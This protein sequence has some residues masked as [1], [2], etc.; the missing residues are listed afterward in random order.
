M[1]RDS[2][3]GS[4]CTRGDADRLAQVLDNLLDNAIRYTQAG[5]TVTV[6]LRSIENLIE[7]AVSDQGPGI[8]ADHLPMIFERFY[9]AEAS[10]SRSDGGAGLGLA[11]ARA[12][13][14]AHGGRI[15]A[16]SALGHGTTITFSVPCSSQE[17]T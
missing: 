11:I 7:C 16:R 17:K 13:V 5:S 1:D 8:P 2:Q 3:P 10:R 4:F 14:E 6:S 12:L 15:T 9:R